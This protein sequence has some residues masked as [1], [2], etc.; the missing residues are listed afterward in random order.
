[1]TGRRLAA[2]RRSCRAA[3]FI[4]AGLLSGPLWA[5]TAID[6]PTPV[7]FPVGWF[8]LAPSVT[9]GYSFNSN[10]FLT[11]KDISVADRVRT[12]QPAVQLT[13]P[14]SN[15]TI[16]LADALNVFDYKTI[17]QPEGKTANDA[18]LDFTFRFSSMD[19]LDASVRHD[20]GVSQTSTE[21]SQLVGNELVKVLQTA[22]NPYRINAETVSMSR[23]I[24]G[25][26]GYRFVLTRNTLD[27]DKPTPGS[28][29]TY[30]GYDGEAAYIQP[31]SSNTRFAIG[32]VGAWYDE[33]NISVGS[34]PHAPVRT[35]RGNTI[36]AEFGGQLGP[37]Q[38]YSTRLG[39][40]NL[41][42]ETIPPNSARGFSG[43]VVDARLGAIVGGGTAFT[44]FAKRQPYRSYFFDNNYYV[45]GQ[46]GFQVNRAFPRGSAVGGELSLIR[47]SYPE[48]SGPLNIYRRD[49]GIRVEA[50]ANL[51]ISDR[52]SFRVSVLRDERKS[53]YP[54]TDYSSTIIF[55]GMVFGWI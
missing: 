31:L 45:F 22:A 21:T 49:R 53:T 55:G 6:I 39:W 48:P 7:G 33:F 23:E 37:K 14:F 27:F 18:F 11:P 35:E 50:Y 52:L 2:R 19:T 43:V 26:R 34:N 4:A 41:A 36:Y 51:A 46:A 40:T 20:T 8:Y 10:I 13:V 47:N 24:G 54:G 32:Y 44:A 12:V 30:K 28:Y 38:P 5:E 25:K 9:A 29:F 17:P 3:A 1:M 42:F 15:S 16:R